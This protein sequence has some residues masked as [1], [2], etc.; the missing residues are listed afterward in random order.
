[1]KRPAAR[2]WRCARRR[3]A[4]AGSG[5]LF[6]ILRV[7][8]DKRSPL[9]GQIFLGEDCLHRAFVHA[10]AAIDARVGVNVQLLGLLEDTAFTSLDR[11]QLLGTSREIEDR[12]FRVGDGTLRVSFQSLSAFENQTEVYRHLAANTDLDIHVYGEAD[13]TPPAIDDITYHETSDDTVE[14]FWVVAFDGGSERGQAC[15][16]V[17]RAE[18]DD[19]TG[20]WTY[21]PKSV[22]D[23][24]AALETVDG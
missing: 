4:G 5:R 11:R 15:A 20:F 22:D 2:L 3:Q 16:L 21:D 12:A 23:V 9:L 19:Y 6:V 24:L 17:A 14:R 1:M 8:F 18:D 7:L 10:Q 13:W